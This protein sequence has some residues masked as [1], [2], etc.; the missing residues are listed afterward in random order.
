MDAIEPIVEAIKAACP[1]GDDGEEASLSEREWLQRLAAV[2]GDADGDGVPQSLDLLLGIARGDAAVRPAAGGIQ[3]VPVADI[4]LPADPV[5]REPDPDAAARLAASVA[6]LGILEP[7]LLRR[8]VEG[9]EVVAGARRLAAARL[10]GFAEV[11]AILLQ[12]AD[13]EA[14]MVGLVENLQRDD[15]AALD[16]AHCYTRLIETFGW[17]QD[18]LA[19]QLGRSRSHIANTMRLTGL[20]EAVK[21]LLATG[22]LSAGH[23]RALLTARDPVAIARAVVGR[24]LSVR[25]TEALVQSERP[26]KEPAAQRLDQALNQL[27][28]KLSI[29]LGLTVRLQ[30]TRQGGKVTIYYNSPKELEEAL[31]HYAE[32]IADGGSGPAP[33]A[34]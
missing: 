28:Q 29:G 1:V 21:N 32:A 24:E 11:P 6:E 16:E 12:L 13:R 23:A 34:S 10:V 30:P 4:H 31:L 5:R 14:L 22:A 33:S 19:R 15:L 17:T 3:T 27:E 18:E 20:P 26:P 2:T 9:Y 8:A 25:Q 7:L